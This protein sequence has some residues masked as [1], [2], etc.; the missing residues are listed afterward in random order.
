MW[1][2]VSFLEVSCWC[3]FSGQ[4]QNSGF[5]EFQPMVSYKYKGSAT[6]MVNRVLTSAT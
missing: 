5:K 1:E 4:N 2:A 3:C 6:M